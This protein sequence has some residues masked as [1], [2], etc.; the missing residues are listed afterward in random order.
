MKTFVLGD[1][2]GGQAGDTEKLKGFGKE[3]SKDDVVINLGDFGFIWYHD[4]HPKRKKDDA[5]LKWLSSQNYT[6]AFVDGNHENFDLINNSP[7]V[8]KWCGKVNEVYPGIYRLRRG[9]IYNINGKSIFVLGGAMSNPNQKE[10]NYEGKGKFKKEKLQKVW[11]EQEIPS[12]EEFEYSLNNLKKH[13]FKVDFILTHTC[14][15]ETIKDIFHKTGT[16]DYNR[17]SDPVSIFLDSVLDKVEFKEWHFGHHH[18][19]VDLGNIFCHYKNKPY[20]LKNF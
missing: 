14:A 2:H 9:E 3:L 10:G 15:S 11:W 12:K 20:E 1:M 19:D 7:I 8:E 4:K 18:Q 16:A 6:F 17:L 13:N 5:Y